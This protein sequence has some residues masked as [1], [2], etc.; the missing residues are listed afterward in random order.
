[1]FSRMTWPS[2]STPSTSALGKYFLKAR[3]SCPEPHPK[4]KNFKECLLAS[5]WSSGWPSGSSRLENRLCKSM[6][7]GGYLSSDPGSSTRVDSRLC[8]FTATCN[9]EVSSSILLENLL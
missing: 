5:L 3:T 2:A 6:N 1:M 9:S 8:C 7:I 4:D